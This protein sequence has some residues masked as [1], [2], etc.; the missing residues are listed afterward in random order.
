M[1]H[2]R[3]KRLEN[4]G[5]LVDADVRITRCGKLKMLPNFDSCLNIFYWMRESKICFL[6]NTKCDNCHHIQHKET[7]R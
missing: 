2:L 3:R 4:L 5:T 6:S 1:S 7:W